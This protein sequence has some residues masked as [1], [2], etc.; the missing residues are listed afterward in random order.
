MF[1]IESNY[2]SFPV[3]LKRYD[4]YS[5]YMEIYLAEI[6]N[7]K[8]ISLRQLSIM[9]GISKT[10]LNDIENGKVSPTFLQLEKISRAMHLKIGDFVKSEFL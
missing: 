4:C 5:Y 3:S 1:S 2:H 7:E 9:T 10:T 6:R 8:K